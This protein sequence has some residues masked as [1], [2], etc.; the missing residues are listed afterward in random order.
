MI[1]AIIAQVYCPSSSDNNLKKV[2]DT[3]KRR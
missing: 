3:N 1:F 2:M